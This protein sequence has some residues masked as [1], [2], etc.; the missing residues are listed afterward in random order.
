MM[1]LTQITL[2]RMTL[3]RTRI[4]DK[5]KTRP[6]GRVQGPGSLISLLGF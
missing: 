4:L 5:K 1:T 3:T 2:T 6:Y